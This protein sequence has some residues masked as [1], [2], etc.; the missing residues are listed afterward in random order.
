MKLWKLLCSVIIISFL[1]ISCSNN[2]LDTAKEKEAET[3]EIE[4]I[5]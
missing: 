1:L 4:D 2:T 3:S 5:V